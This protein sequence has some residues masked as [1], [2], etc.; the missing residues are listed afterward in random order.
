[1]AQG[2]GNLSA[3]E[4]LES[5]IAKKGFETADL[6][7]AF[8]KPDGSQMD[9][10]LRLSPEFD[11]KSELANGRA[12]VLTKTDCLSWNDLK[13]S[14]RTSCFYNYLPKQ[15]GG[16]Y[17]NWVFAQSAKD[18]S[19]VSRKSAYD[20]LASLRKM[21]PVAP[22]GGEFPPAWGG[23]LSVVLSRVATIW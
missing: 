5:E 10:T 15:F 19:I 12:K 6:T 17:K 2:R 7:S 1:M 16:N 11:L 3:I 23:G 8:A 14:K 21:G 13:T 4:F 22:S 9:L 20:H 18:W